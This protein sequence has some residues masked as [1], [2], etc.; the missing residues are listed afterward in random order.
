METVEM[1][2]TCT[3]EDV[4]EL[5]GRLCGNIR[6]VSSSFNAQRPD[7]LLPSKKAVIE[8]MDSLMTVLF[9]GFFGGMDLAIVNLPFKIGAELDHIQRLLVK[10]IKRGCCFSCSKHSE[11]PC[12]DCREKA[13][14][15]SHRFMSRLEFIQEC[16]L[17]DAEAS[18]NGDP[19]ATSVEECIFSYPGLVAVA[20]YR[21]AHELHRL[22][23]PILPRIITERAHSMTGIDIHPGAVIGK[24]FFIDHGTGVVIG[25]TC[26]IGEN[27]TLYQGVTLGAK[28]FPL[29]ENGHPIKGVPRHPIVR[30][31]AVIYAG[32]TVLGRITIGR[33]AV[34]GGNAWVTKDV[35]D[36]VGGA[37]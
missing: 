1:H 27:V 29:D 2:T 35:P 15:I 30:S 10:Q 21:I 37:L 5:A 16:L 11:G 3:N 36:N 8:I 22:G 13:R 20:H 6:R 26:E 19:A 18:F 32:A 14:E 4:S 9:P 25:E 31:G 12:G 28:N 34:I 23:V 17:S 7:I 24:G 33:G